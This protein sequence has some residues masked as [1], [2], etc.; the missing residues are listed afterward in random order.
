MQANQD[1]PPYVTFEQRAVEDRAATEE[2]GHYVARDVIYAIIT[3]MGSK[4]KIE[5]VAEEWFKQ[6]RQQVQEGRFLLEWLKGYELAYGDFK[7]GRETPLNGTPI[8]GWNVVSPALQKTIVDGA[9]IR[10]VE[11]LAVANESAIMLLGIGGRGLK[12]KAQAWLD[13]SKDT[14]TITLE[15]EKLRQGME[16]LK[17]RLDTVTEERDALAK[18]VEP[19][20]GK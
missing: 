13:S 18:Q 7:E 12:Q 1:R 5:K 10:T 19:T 4:D 15:L 2:A 17:I 9:G 14:G 6:L 3:P 11:D 16:E 20:K 8:L